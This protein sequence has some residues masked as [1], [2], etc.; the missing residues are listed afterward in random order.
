MVRGV[1]EEKNMKKN[2]MLKVYLLDISV[3]NTN[4]NIGQYRNIYIILSLVFT[5]RAATNASVKIHISQ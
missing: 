3:R 4:R 1:K 5:Y 2:Q